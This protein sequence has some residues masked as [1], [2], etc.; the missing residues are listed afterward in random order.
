MITPRRPN[1]LAVLLCIAGLLVGPHSPGFA[2]EIE[3]VGEERPNVLWII[4]E[5][6]GPELGAYRALGN[7][8]AT[9]VR[10]PSLDR[11]AQEGML[12]THTF[13]TS[14]VCSPSRSAFNTGMYQTTISAHEH[15]SHRPG[16]PSP[17]PFPLP[18]S[19]RLVNDWLHHAGFFTGN[20]TQF[21]DSLALEGTGKTDWNFSYDGE[22]FDTE[23]WSELAARQPFYA[24]VNFSET[25]RGGAWQ[26]AQESVEEPVDPD[27]VTIP[28]YYPDH[29]VVRREW[30][31]YLNTVMALDR[32]VGTVLDLL[33]AEGLADNTVVMFFADHGRAMV[34]GK[35]W[36]YDSG[37]RVPLIVRWP[38]GRAAPDGY[39]AGQTSDQLIS[40]ILGSHHARDGWCS[41]TGGDAGANLSRRRCRPAA[42]LRLRWAGPGRRDGRP[43][44]DRAHAQIPLY[45]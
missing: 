41:Q 13:T 42:P 11:L 3:P 31:E 22:P 29:P 39:A 38:E 27:K 2:Q 36:P 23:R 9:G 21:P 26:A 8:L 24:Q 5:D 35:Q 28:P 7:E 37:L 12:Y 1:F 33:E 20:I 25:H 6:M 14:P 10:T 16:D 44:A 19:V 30:A 34:R 40:A 18:D 4:A 45:P 17:Y 43:D 32:K 15:R